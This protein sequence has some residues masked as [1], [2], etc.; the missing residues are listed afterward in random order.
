MVSEISLTHLNT[1]IHDSSTLFSLSANTAS[2]VG[3]HMKQAKILPECVVKFLRR[4]EE[5]S[6]SA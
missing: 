6:T 2:T 3:E 1:K 4:C 5:A